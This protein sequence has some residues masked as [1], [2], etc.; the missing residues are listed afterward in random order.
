MEA[1]LAEVLVEADDGRK[2]FLV[3][4]TDLARACWQRNR[5]SH[6]AW[7]KDC[8]AM[9]KWVESA[10]D[11]RLWAYDCRVGSVQMFMQVIWR[12]SRTRV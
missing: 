10:R 12:M 7:K 1:V 2:H 9:P 5:G 8:P 4:G 11:M 6:A 3:T